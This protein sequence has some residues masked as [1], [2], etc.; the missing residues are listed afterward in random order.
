MVPVFQHGY[1]SFHLSLPDLLLVRSILGRVGYDETLFQLFGTIRF[2]FVKE[3]T[4]VIRSNIIKINELIIRE[5]AEPLTIKSKLLILGT[6]LFYRLR[7]Y[8]G[9]VLC[10]IKDTV[11]L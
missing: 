5:P 10:I 7:D 2:L 4:I 1:G 3:L 9:S 11:I 6:Q 8:K